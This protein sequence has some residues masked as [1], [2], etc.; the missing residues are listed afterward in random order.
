MKNKNIV[1]FLFDELRCDALGCYGNKYVKMKTPAIDE[2]ANQGVLFKNCYCNS[3]VCVPSRMSIL[4]GMFPSESGVYHNEAMFFPYEKK[5][6]TIPSILKEH[7]YTCANFGKLHLPMGLQPFDI[8]CEEGSAMSLGLNKNE[9]VE[10]YLSPKGKFHSTIGGLYPSEMKYAPEKVVE[11]ALA[12]M[13]KQSE[14]YFVRISFLQPHTPIIVKQPFD[15]VYENEAF[16]SISDYQD[17]SEFERQFS[18]MIELSTLNESEIQQ[19][20]EHYYGMVAWLDTQVQ[21]VVEYLKENQ[22]YDDT[23]IIVGAD[24]G[25][26]RGENGCLAKQIFMKPSHQVPLIFSC[27]SKIKHGE[28]VQIVSNIDIATTIFSLLDIPVHSQFKGENLFANQHDPYVYS[29]I[30]YGEACST[31][32]PNKNYGKWKDNTGWP[33]RACIRSGRYRL[34]MS[35]KQNGLI[36]NEKEEDLFFTDCSIYEN[37]DKNMV[38]D[39]SYQEIIQEMRLKLLAH[40]ANSIESDS[41]KLV[42]VYEQLA[43]HNH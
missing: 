14:P 24:H 25:A 18:K 13:E 10:K 11:N 4:T 7:G 1:Y 20:H 5:V 8:N 15:K 37:E 22:L 43:F 23:L 41:K 32:F 6:E 2:I 12:W 31:A 28:K 30:G 26:S 33:R 9:T 40:L 3:P 35:V 36:V 17:V 21:K 19:M 38:N 27:P 42:S 39:K 16:P 29:C 34:D